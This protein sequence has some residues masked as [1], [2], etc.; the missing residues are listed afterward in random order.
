MHNCLHRAILNTGATFNTLINSN[1]NRFP[2]LNLVDISRSDFH[3]CT[4]AIALIVVHH[5]IHLISFP[6]SDIHF[7]SITDIYVQAAN[8][9]QIHT[10]IAFSEFR[11]EVSNTLPSNN[12]F[13]HPSLQ[14]EYRLIKEVLQS[15]RPFLD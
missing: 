11:L 10:S 14:S 4:V 1:G 9:R 3:T 5:D 8:R 12:A 13:L 7:T 2:M 15:S 6:C